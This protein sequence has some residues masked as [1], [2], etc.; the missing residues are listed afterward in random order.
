M[1]L[2]T[3]CRFT[4]IAI[5]LLQ[6]A[7]CSICAQTKKPAS[8]ENEAI[9]HYTR[10]L[11][12]LPIEYRADLLLS[13]VE[14]HPRLLS[15]PAIAQEL[16]DVFA[17]APSAE[18]A[19]PLAFASIRTED[20]SESQIAADSQQHVD[21]LSIQTRVIT[22]LIA[23]SPKEALLLA[24]EIR[25]PAESTPCS[26]SMV[27]DP[28]A[29]YQMMERNL[30][31]WV[32]A[33]ALTSQGLRDLLE[34]HFSTQMKSA[35]QIAAAAHLLANAPLTDEDFGE[36]LAVYDASLSRLQLSDRELGW[37]IQEADLYSQIRALVD[38]SIKLHESATPTLSQL[39][40]LILQ[41]LHSRCSDALV[42]AD[43]V[44]QELNGL[45]GRYQPYDPTLALDS[46]LLSATQD[47]KSTL[48]PIDPTG[49]DDV[50]MQTLSKYAGLAASVG[51]IEDMNGWEM[52][53]NEVLTSLESTQT[54]TSCEIC[55]FY[56]R[57][58][59][60]WLLI[61]YSPAAPISRSQE[62]ALSSYA[63]YLSSS[64][65]KGSEPAA[66][67]S[68]A[69]LLIN[70]SRNADSEQL[71]RIEQFQSKGIQ[72]MGLPS[73][74]GRVVLDELRQTRDPICS[75]Y[76][77]YEALFHPGWTSPY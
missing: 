31:L 29:Y 58:I 2:Q 16:E 38:K 27:S 25:F 9:L 15:Q 14:S 54:S 63:R 23:N 35:T 52:S 26:T 62:S 33:K 22:R 73:P 71:H 18:H 41:G 72:L 42:N 67:I 47:E 60:Y 24:A 59:R 77:R 37:L 21:T 19:F 7:S 32:S 17:A 20:V 70:F 55:D 68:K 57:Y 48:H 74:S 28:T 53:A 51:H 40:A 36:L 45:V 5:G 76:V 61:N 8:A 39:R 43:R 6:P 44:I 11:S 69:K 30:P 64:D 34:L 66:W 10:T 13:A 4:L 75:A 12:S 46:K 49:P 3:L 65:I 56:N 1:N 50:K